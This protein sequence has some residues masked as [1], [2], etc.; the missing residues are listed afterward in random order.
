MAQNSHGRG[1]NQP[2]DRRD[3]GGKETQGDGDNHQT[4]IQLRGRERDHAQVQIIALQAANTVHADND[5]DD[6]KQ[7]QDVGDEA[8]D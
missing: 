2:K 6:H 1:T 4:S 3:R 8:V 7:Q 5:Q